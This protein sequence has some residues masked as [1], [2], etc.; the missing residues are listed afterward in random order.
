MAFSAM[1]GNLESDKEMLRE[2]FGMY[3]SGEISDDDFLNKLATHLGIDKQEVRESLAKDEHLDN[4]L[5]ELIKKLRKKYKIGLLSNIGRG[6]AERYFAG[7]DTSQ[8]FDDM[9]LSGEVGMVK[10][11]PGIY[12][13]A[14]DRLEVKP[15]ECVFIDDSERNCSAAEEAGMRT[16]IYKNFEEFKE[17]LSELL[18]QE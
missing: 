10:P 14:A 4:R 7:L 16:I 8:Y 1:G 2:L 12:Q 13:M 17:Q 3:N 11:D 6:G 9:V 15:G 5:L 18:N